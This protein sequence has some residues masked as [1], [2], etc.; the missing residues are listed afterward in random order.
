MGTAGGVGSRKAAQFQTQHGCLNAVHA[1]VPADGRVE[2]LPRLPVVAQRL[3]P[4][5]QFRFVCRNR[6]RLTE[7]AKILAR[8][9]N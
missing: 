3:N 6:P 5:P 7:G 1:G 8:D 4:G 2:M 9:R